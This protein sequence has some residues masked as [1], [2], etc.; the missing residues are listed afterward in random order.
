LS[1]WPSARGSALL[2][3]WLTLRMSGH[4]LPLATIAWGLSLYYTMGN[5]ECL[6]KYDGI[7][8]VPPLSLFGWDWAKGRACTRWSGPW[9]CWRAG[10]HATCWT[11]APA[12]PSA[13]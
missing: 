9:R 12:A 11:R 4:Y 6:G 10:G 5:M 7:L 2:L 1:A 13:R 3:G 8:G